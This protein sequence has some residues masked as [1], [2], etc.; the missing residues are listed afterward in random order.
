MLL[1]LISR[2]VFVIIMP[3]G[4]DPLEDAMRWL[5]LQVAAIPLDGAHDL[6]PQAGGAGLEDTLAFI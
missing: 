3:L 4:F 2:T 6:C 5:I 1:F